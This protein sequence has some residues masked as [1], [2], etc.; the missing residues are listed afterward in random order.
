MEKTIGIYPWVVGLTKNSDKHQKHFKEALEKRGYQVIPIIYKKGFPISNALKVKVDILILDWVHSFYTSQSLYSSIIKS[1]LG[2]LELIFLPKEDT[3]IIW[4]LHN[5][6]RHDGKFQQIEKVCFQQLAKK[7]DYIRV[8]DKSHIKK[9][10]EHLKVNSKKI[11]IIPQG[12]Y[13]YKENI[14]INIYERYQIQRDK[15]ILLFFGNIRNGKGIIKFIES[16]SNILNNKYVLLIAG[17][18]ND[19][20]FER[21]INKYINNNI[22]F[23]NRFIPDEEV[24]SYFKSSNRI[25]LPYEN[26]LNS[27]VLLLARTYGI[28]IL[29]NE[30]FINYKIDNDIIGDLFNHVELDLILSKVNSITKLNYVNLSGWESIVK[31]YEVYFY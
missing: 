16:F 12:P 8:F 15:K 23:V 26:T 13:V 6:Q 25:V 21:A 31:E 5:L 9:V 18:T 19:L 14:N 29:A 11:I 2:L 22:I 20:Q 10:S 17:K 4:N 7:V 3:I 1:F 28:P 27:G 30:N 24:N